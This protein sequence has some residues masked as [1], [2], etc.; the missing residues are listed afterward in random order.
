MP[1]DPQAQALLDQMKGMGAK[2]FQ[3]M[4]VAEAREFMASFRAL[5]GTPDPVAHVSDHRIPGPAGEIPVRL[6]RPVERTPLPL[7]AYFHGGGWVIG[8]LESHDGTLR[9]LAN[10]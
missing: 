2:S 1:L 8:G 3:D 9:T 4:T 6:Y 7:L 10:A 5:V